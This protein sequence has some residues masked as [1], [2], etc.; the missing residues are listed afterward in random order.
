MD[1]R[2]WID[3]DNSPHVLFF[4]PIITSLLDRGYEI[5]ITAR[6]A[7]QVIELLE[8]LHLHARVIGR[9][10][11]KNK[12]RKIT[13]LMLRALELWP[14]VR[15]FKPNL[16][17]SHGSRSQMI[18]ARSLGIKTI[19]ILDY[20]FIRLIPLF[21]P[22]WIIL[23]EII[24]EEAFA[25]RGIKVLKYPGIKENVYIPDFVPNPAL[26]SELHLNTAGRVIIAIRPPATE[27]HYF[28]KESETVF[29]AL[30][31]HLSQRDDVVA[32]CLAR[33]RRESDFIKS[34][35][36]EMYHQKRLILPEQALDGLSLIWYSDLVISGGGTMNR[37]AA[38]LGVP[39]Y[40]IY[41][42]AT[43]AVDRYLAKQ[44][45]LIFI[46][47]QEDIRFKIKIEKRIIRQNPTSP[48]IPTKAAIISAI[49]QI[50]CEPAAGSSPC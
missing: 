32:V 41:Q 24:A 43:G 23:P 16:A 25:R 1:H 26:I 28:V 17:V 42:G 33:T 7:F 50:L 36:P 21:T 9:H 30:M 44:G 19:L 48:V 40:S 29:E 20:E 13:G 35:W 3:L 12:F 38:V 31:N 34:C 14:A 11:G 5:L 45:K 18:L 15:K 10:H 22:Q 2:I 6:D 39:V 46:R 47:D 37:E 27:A 8:E 49:E 4:K